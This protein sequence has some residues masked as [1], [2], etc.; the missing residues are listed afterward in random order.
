MDRLVLS[1][2]ERNKLLF[3]KTATAR[4]LNV[5]RFMIERIQVWDKTIWVK[6]RGEKPQL[7]SQNIYFNHFVTY[8]QKNSTNLIAIKEDTAKWQVINPQKE[9]W[10][11]VNLVGDRLTC[12]CEDYKNQINILKR[13]CCKHCYKVLNEIGCHSLSDY[14]NKVN[15]TKIQISA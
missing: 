5:E 15:K 6:M 14:V 3:S 13:G 4:I 2:V 11:I 12:T 10:N 1:V 9:T 7:I 8:R